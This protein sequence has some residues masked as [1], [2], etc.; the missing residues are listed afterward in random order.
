[1]L[2]QRELAAQGIAAEVAPTFLPYASRTEVRFENYGGGI[3]FTDF[4]SRDFDAFVR[5]N[6][7]WAR[8]FA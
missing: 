2:S 4:R 8:R 6:S 5:I 7:K 3:V 1:V